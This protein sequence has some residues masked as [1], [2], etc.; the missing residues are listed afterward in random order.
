MRC[1]VFRILAHGLDQRGPKMHEKIEGPIMSKI[2]FFF[3]MCNFCTIVLCI[4]Y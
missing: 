3:K 2:S 4:V 1:L